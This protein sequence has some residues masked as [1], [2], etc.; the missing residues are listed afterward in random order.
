MNH[1]DIDWLLGREFTARL[2][3]LA[4]GDPPRYRLGGSGDGARTVSVLMNGRGAEISLA[5]LRTMIDA[6][7][8]VEKES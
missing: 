8:L 5:E 1:C 6:G 7:V 3:V 2:R 4:V